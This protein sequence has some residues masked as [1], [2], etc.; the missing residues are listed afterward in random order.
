MATAGS[1]SAR[2][3]SPPG[4]RCFGYARAGFGCGGGAKATRWP[5]PPL[6][7]AVTPGLA[8]GQSGRQPL[9]AVPGRLAAAH[10]Q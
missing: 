10:A 7:A 2:V 3:W 5:A 9:Y 8:A 1:R 4:R 6:A